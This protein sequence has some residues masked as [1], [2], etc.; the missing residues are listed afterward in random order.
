MSKD[1]SK[2]LEWTD[3]NWEA[4]VKEGLRRCM[5]H[6][7]LDDPSACDE[8]PYQDGDCCD[9]GIVIMPKRLAKDVL[10]MLEGGT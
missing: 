6:D 10:K 7:V 2:T 1:K 9:G 4:R 8:C 5:I 3:V